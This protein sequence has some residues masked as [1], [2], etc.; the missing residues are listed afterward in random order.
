VKRLTF[1]RA[2]RVY[3]GGDVQRAHH[4]ETQYGDTTMSSYAKIAL[5]AALALGAASAACAKDR[6]NSAARSEKDLWESQHVLYRNHGDKNPMLQDRAVTK[7]S[8]AYGSA[9]DFHG[10]ETY[11]GVQ[12]R[13]YRESIG[14]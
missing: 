9:P 2:T 10:E 1:D 5:A 11:I 7:G 14:E 6:D 12:D 4:P 8:S 3:R 13:L